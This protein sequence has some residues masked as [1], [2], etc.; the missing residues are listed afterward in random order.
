[1]K[2]TKSA[3]HQ[4]SISY[5]F[6]I[7]LLCFIPVFILYFIVSSIIISVLHKQT[8]S[9]I[10]TSASYY[11]E[12]MNTSQAA[13][14]LFLID[15]VSNKLSEHVDFENRN[16]VSYIQDVK[17]IQ[18][19]VKQLRDYYGTQY[20]YFV[21]DRNADYFFPC[22]TTGS[23]YYKDQSEQIQDEILSVVNTPASAA[24]SD[25]WSNYQAGST[26]FLMKYYQYNDY[27]MGCWV[28]AKDFIRPFASMNLGPKGFITLTDEQG[29]P[30][31]NQSLVKEQNISLTTLNDTTKQLSLFSKYLIL[32]FTLKKDRV[33]IKIIVDQFGA[34]G[35]IFL[36][37]IAI[38]VFVM[39]LVGLLLLMTLYMRQQVLK[40]IRYFSENLAVYQED[41]PVLDFKSNDIIELELANTQFKN[42][43]RQIKKLKIDIYE[44]ELEHMQIQMN[45]MQL[46]IRPHF[47]LNCLNS[48][49]SMG[50]T[51]CYDEMNQMIVSTSDYFRYIFQCK[52][53]FVL[54]DHEFTHTRDY[55]EIQKI[56]YG[57]GFYY[58]LEQQSE[59]KGLQIPPLIIQT[60]I[61]NSIKHTVTLDEEVHI[62]LSAKLFELPDKNRLEILIT[63]T[64]KGFDPETLEI[65]NKERSLSTTDGHR[66]G[67]TNTIHRLDMLYENQYSISFSNL[68]DGGASVC[69]LLP[70]DRV[71]TSI[72]LP[73]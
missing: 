29:N 14:N 69:L 11:T 38:F 13:I 12:E 48:I 65:L 5:Y 2:R 61:E 49:Y 34:Y 30:A 41:G 35:S 39:I 68:K 70:A 40:P 52:E 73:S 42:L 25:L 20:N 45:Y 72:P 58:H 54:L 71:H 46:Q 55:L 28:D 64:G 33:S 3:R 8:M 17:S 22:N 60:F 31:T 18:A 50:Q 6:R 66:I 56:R 44:K 57:S 21:Y 9:F 67:I 1:M 32:G 10:E 43:I 23:F 15:Y 24:V 26:V 59:T 51:E 16:T 53:D 37:Q 27:V 36:V 63:D 47:F 19:D 4:H 62:S 7:V